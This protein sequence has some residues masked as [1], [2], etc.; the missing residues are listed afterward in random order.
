MQQA[1]RLLD[2][3]IAKIRFNIRD[4]KG[5]AQDFRQLLATADPNSE[6][7]EE[8]KDLLLVCSEFSPNVELNNY[9]K[10][11]YSDVYYWAPFI[12]VGDWK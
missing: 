2:W 3:D 7:Y 5:A 11:V 1:E 9:Q 8:L 10:L 12:L 6:E 4:G